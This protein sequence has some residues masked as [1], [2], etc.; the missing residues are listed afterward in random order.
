MKTEG[1]ETPGSPGPA[2]AAAGPRTALTVALVDDHLALRR[3]IE[4]LLEQEGCRVVG[5]AAD[6]GAAFE[7]IR[8]CRP[9]VSVIDI[10]LAGDSG[11]ELTR[12]L[13]EQDPG[14]GIL[15]YTGLQD[16]HAL[17]E[18]LDSGARGFAM[19][20]GLPEELLC[21]IRSSQPAV[22]TS[23]PVSARCWSSGGPLLG[24]GGCPCARPTSSA[25]WPRA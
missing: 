4:L 24:S 9:D 21:A 14:L 2:P 3:G 18:G 10:A 12:R 17:L 23:T 5:S 20:A 8:A 15:L 13:L 11:V 16:R 25:C 7:L 1:K 19:K 6:A 22:T